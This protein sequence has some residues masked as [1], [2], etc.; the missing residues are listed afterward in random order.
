MG[1][2][3]F[4]DA[5]NARYA[6]MSAAD[7][8]RHD[9]EQSMPYAQTFSRKQ[10]PSA[11]AWARFLTLRCALDE[12]IVGTPIPEKHTEKRGANVLAAREDKDLAISGV[13]RCTNMGCE[14]EGHDVERYRIVYT[15]GTVTEQF[16]CPRSARWLEIDPMYNC[17]SIEPAPIND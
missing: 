5:A 15:H 2:S 4:V 16:L 1:R 14:H 3:Y 6:R 10:F 11:A 7:K 17:A 13:A 9:L 8:A 12:Q